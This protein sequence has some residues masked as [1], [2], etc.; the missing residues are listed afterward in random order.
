M[1]KVLIRYK[2]RPGEVQENVSL[3]RA[4]FHEL[5]IERPP[6]LIYEAYLLADG[7]SFVH[8]VDSTTGAQP[9]GHLPSYRRYR[10][11]VAARCTEPPQMIGMDPVGVFNALAN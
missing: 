2:L 3:L 5:E 10:D 9:F 6:G 11:T 1:P 4:F 7:L 8:I